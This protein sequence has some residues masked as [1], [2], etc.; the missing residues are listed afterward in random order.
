MCSVCL[1]KT[2]TNIANEVDEV[3]HVEQSDWLEDNRVDELDLNLE[4]LYECN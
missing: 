1:G 2:C 3:D 4:G